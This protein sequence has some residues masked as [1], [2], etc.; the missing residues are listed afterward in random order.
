MPKKTLNEEQDTYLRLIA[1]GK[2]VK[3]CTDLLNKH[4]GTA[5]TY[6]QI[7]SYK[8]NHKIGSGMKP[9]E[10]VDHS[11]RRILT[12]EQ[13]TFVRKN[14]QGI[15]NKELIDLFNRTFDTN[16]TVNQ[17]KSHKQRNK[18][19]SGLTGCFEKGHVPANK[20]TKGLYNVGGNKTSFKKGEAPINIDPV[21]TEKM[22]SD[23]YIWVKIDNQSNVP[24]GVNWRQKHRLIFEQHHNIKL[25]KED[26][27]V[28][29]DGDR[30]NFDID[31]LILV[32]NSEMLIMNRRGLL[33]K[34]KELTKTGAN[35]AKV[36]NKVNTIQKE[37]KKNVKK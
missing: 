8:S 29:A 9:W 32:S 7:K 1:Q 18:I 31:N 15:S 28:F 4:F 6:N 17:I 22:L 14:A 26:R 30:T 23:G 33:Y 10:F 34:D 21:G 12:N 16:F 25:T 27:C 2:S 36:L 13:D 3:E 37:N 19:T 20:G 35:I 5:F 11:D 24:K